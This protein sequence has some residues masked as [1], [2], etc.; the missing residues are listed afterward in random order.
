M[1]AARDGDFQRTAEYLD[2]RYLTGGMDKNDGPQ[3]ARQLKISLDKLLWFDMELV[4]EHPDG[5]SDDGLPANR[6][7]LILVDT[8]LWFEKKLKLN[9]EN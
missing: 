2:L 6:C 9:K 5:F 8:S 7:T 3:V 4:S 1:K